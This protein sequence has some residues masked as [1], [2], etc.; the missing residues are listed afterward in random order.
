MFKYAVIEL[1]RRKRRSISVVIAY[2][3]AVIFFS[4][5][6]NILFKSQ[7]SAA[8]I[9]KS[10]GT[11]FVAYLPL[12]NNDSCLN[13]AVD[14]INEGFYAE[15]IKSKL[16]PASVVEAVKRL[17]SVKDAA[18][19]L[20][21][22]LRLKINGLDDS[23]LLGGIP[24]NESIAVA[25]NSCSNANIVEGR[26]ISPDDDSSVML[27]EGFAKRFAINCK[28]KIDIGKK[29]FLVTGI[30][31]SGIKAVKAD[32]YI[33]LPKAKEIINERLINPINDE[34]NIILVESLNSKVHQ[35]AV[36]QV[37][38]TLGSG[39]IISSYNCF[40]PA[41]AVLG[42]N[43]K[44]AWFITLLIFISILAFSLRAQYSS[45]IERR[46]QIG[47]L[48]VIGWSKKDFLLQFFYESVIQ[49]LTG[50]ITG[51][52][53]VL[54]IIL[55]S[56]LFLT[57]SIKIFDIIYY[58]LILLSNLLLTVSGGIIAGIIPGI[59]ASMLKPAECLRRL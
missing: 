10:T 21:F 41:S 5:I 6:L 13:I 16:L 46:H 53:V 12:C 34:F 58:P 19:F 37:I 14:S 15:N 31:N 1:L 24:L 40:K 27:E 38:N 33:S 43:G 26:F 23:F 9:L 52:F 57:D 29:T 51:S 11:H 42:I 50:F 35:E 30:V 22:K 4:L 25:N 39:S 49:S 2:M 59:S 36:N 7:N 17:N 28:D 55:L 20:L 18:P 48:T 54:L 32:I 8:S 56:S 44:S 3:I 47:I 45:I